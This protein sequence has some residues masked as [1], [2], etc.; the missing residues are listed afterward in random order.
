MYELDWDNLEMKFTYIWLGFKHGPF[1]GNL[2]CEFDI[3]SDFF[4]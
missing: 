3:P 1:H 2:V 4:I